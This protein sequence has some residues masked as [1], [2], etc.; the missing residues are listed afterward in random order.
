DGERTTDKK[1]SERGGDDEQDDSRA[2]ATFW[3]AAGGVRRRLTER[4]FSAHA[5]DRCVY[6]DV[7]KITRGG[8]ATAAVDPVAERRVRGTQS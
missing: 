5:G 6:A 2:V 4:D 7:R 8:R 3:N 1:G